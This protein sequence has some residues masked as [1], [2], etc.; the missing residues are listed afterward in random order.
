MNIFDGSKVTGKREYNP[1]RGELTCLA[2]VESENSWDSGAA[3]P[4]LLQCTPTIPALRSQ[5]IC[6]NK[7]AKDIL[8]STHSQENRFDLLPM[9]V[10]GIMYCLYAIALITSSSHFFA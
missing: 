6:Q 3:F 10:D 2:V 1:I 5:Y 4:I 9:P 8:K 7:T